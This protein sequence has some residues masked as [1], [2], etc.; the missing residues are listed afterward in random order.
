MSVL[1]VEQAILAKM[2]NAKLT[3]IRGTAD[4]PQL[5]K[6]QLQVFQNLCFVGSPFSA[7]DDGH[8]GLGMTTAKYQ[9]RA[10]QPVFN[11]PADPGTHDLTIAPNAG[12]IIRAQREAAHHETLLIY[13]TCKAV[14]VVIKSQMKNAFPSL[15]L[16]EI[17]DEI[18]GPNGV[19]ITDI[20]NH[21]FQWRGQINDMLVTENQ[22]KINEPFT[23][24]E[25]MTD[26]IRR[27]DKCQQLATN[28]NEPWSV[29]QLVRKGKTIIGKCGFMVNDYT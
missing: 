16:T 21:L 27:I 6:I 12:L 17:E 22:A 13:K 20:I 24:N 2:P 9:Q 8:L 7:G 4:Y 3:K 15:L 29:S 5:R 19:I 11:Y 26:Y 18:T 1:K 10:G 25:G 14:E 23:H 28:K